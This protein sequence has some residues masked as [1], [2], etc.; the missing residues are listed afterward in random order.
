MN[1][2]ATARRP[3]A[4]ADSLQRQR[5]RLSIELFL[6]FGLPVMSIAAC[7]ILAFVAYAEGYT[8]LATLPTSASHV[9]AGH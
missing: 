6:L 8:E 1:A 2:A 3:T 4:T 7:A 9:S 5:R